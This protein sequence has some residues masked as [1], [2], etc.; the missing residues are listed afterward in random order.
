MWFDEQNRRVTAKAG[1]QPRSASVWIQFS[2]S[3][4]VVEPHTS[5]VVKATIT[6]PGDA[7]GS[8]YTVPIFE[9]A[10][11]EKTVIPKSA[12]AFTATASIA[13]RFCALMMLTTETGA[14]FNVEIMNAID[15]HSRLL[16]ASVAR[17]TFKAADVVAVFHDAAACHGLPSSLLTDNGA[18]FTAAPR[19]GGRCAIEVECDRIGIRLV[20]SRPYHPQ[21]CAPEG[22]M[23]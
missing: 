13:L 4:V 22:G 5:G 6:V 9:V 18:V 11:L 1:S 7:A 16:V 14:E 12:N 2:P 15:D 10:P 19:G 8:F 20:H 3:E 17:P 23:P 21:T